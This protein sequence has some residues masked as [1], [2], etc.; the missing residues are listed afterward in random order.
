MAP[1]RPSYDL[2]QATAHLARAE[3]RLA[4]LIDLHP[5]FQGRPGGTVMEALGRAIVYQQLSSKAAA[6]IYRRFLRLYGGRFPKAPALLE[7]PDEELRSR[8]LSRAKTVYLKDLAAHFAD[9]RLSGRGL[10]RLDD[11]ELARRLTAVKGIGRW[12]VDMLLIFHLQR[13]DVLP[14]GDLAIRNGIQRLASLDEPPDA[15]T[16]MRLAEPW[17][18]YRSVASWYLWRSIQ[19]NPP[20]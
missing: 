17:R 5:P 6:T 14:V 20:A 9:G 11:E 3:P 10:A 16:M 12:T 1:R 13:P 15:A 7:T 2:A 19:P 4:E 18:P 8:G